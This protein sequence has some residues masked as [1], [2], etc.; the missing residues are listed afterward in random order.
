MWIRF[1][2][3]AP[4]A[5]NLPGGVNA[6]SGEPMVEN[7]A[8]MLRRLN[9]ESNDKSIQDYVVTPKQ[10]WLN[11]IATRDVTVRQFV[12]LVG[13]LQFCVTPSIRETTKHTTRDFAMIQIFIGTLTGKTMNLEVPE[14]ASI[15]EVKYM[16]ELNEGTPIHGQRLIFAGKQLE[17]G[18][19][20]RT[21][22]PRCEEANTTRRFPVSLQNLQGLCGYS[23]LLPR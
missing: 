23:D 9:L 19:L 6:V 15:R 21:M 10:L 16:I 11:G 7:T 5:I 8:T 20:Y 22:V 3:L 1:K 18:E 4:F 17:D 2:S 12:E 14:Y 13:G